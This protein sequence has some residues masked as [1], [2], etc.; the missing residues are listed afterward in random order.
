VQ[1]RPAKSIRLVITDQTLISDVASAVDS[2]TMS[3][4]GIRSCPLAF[5]GPDTVK[6]LLHRGHAREFVFGSC[7]WVGTR[8][9][10]LNDTGSAEDALGLAVYKTLYDRRAKH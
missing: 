5:G 1:G 10:T 9:A 2:L 7:G 3:T 4:G 6:F 8:G